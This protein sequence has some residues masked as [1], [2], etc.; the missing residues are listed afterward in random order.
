LTHR[1]DRRRPPAWTKLFSSAAAAVATALEDSAT[2]EDVSTCT[3][4]VDQL[5]GTCSAIVDDARSLTIDRL[6]GL[7]LRLA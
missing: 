6:N 7:L 1:L 2:R 3:R 4:L 5:A